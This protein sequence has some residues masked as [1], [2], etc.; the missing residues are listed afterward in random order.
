MKPRMGFCGYVLLLT[1]ISGTHA[2]A[3]EA[4]QSRSEY[5]SRRTEPEYFIRLALDGQNHL[6][7]PNQGGLFN[8]GV[9]WWHSLFQRASLYLSVFQPESPKPDEDQARRII[10]SL[11]AGK[12]VVEIP[13]YRNFREFSRDWEDAIQVKLERWQLVDGFLKFK[14]LEGLSGDNNIEPVELQS[15]MDRFQIRTN[16]EN[17]IVWSMW[18]LAGISA[19]SGLLLHVS[20]EPAMYVVPHLDS[21]YPGQVVSFTYQMGQRSVFSSYGPFVPYEGRT[22]DLKRFRAAAEHYCDPEHHPL[23]PNDLDETLSNEWD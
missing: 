16:V 19:H 5:C 20:R 18:Q 15:F 9:C 17:Q 2:V 23:S 6:A 14:W 21:N 1:L 3:E 7:F 22:K 10:H 13:G 8:G 4:P 11:A 12:R